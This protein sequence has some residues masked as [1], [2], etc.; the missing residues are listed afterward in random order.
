MCSL[1]FEKYWKVMSSRE[2]S[3]RAETEEGDGIR[4]STAPSFS[5]EQQK[6]KNQYQS[7]ERASQLQTLCMRVFPF[8]CEPI[9][10]EDP[11][12]TVSTP[13]VVPVWCVSHWLTH[14]HRGRERADS[15]L[16]G[17]ISRATDLVC[18]AERPN[19][20]GWIFSARREPERGT[21]ASRK[22]GL[23]L[24]PPRNNSCMPLM[25]KAALF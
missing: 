9:H 4:V 1:N 17:K 13:A 14:T 5:S 6:K 12:L 15:R 25:L 24:P 16:I 8:G 19:T 23:E 10:R 11:R 18:S 2:K 3:G 22:K 21:A 20:T 7:L